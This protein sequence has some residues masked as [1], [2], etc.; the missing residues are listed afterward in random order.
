MDNREEYEARLSAAC[1]EA[2]LPEAFA[3]PEAAGKLFVVTERLVSCNRQFNL[4]AITEPEEILTKHVVDS[5]F[6][7]AA[8]GTFAPGGGKLLDV[9]AGGGFPSLPVAAALPELSVL[10]MDATAKKCRYI[11]ETAAAAGMANVAVLNARAEEAS[12][13]LGAS[14]D[15]V[16]ARAVARLNV[17][18]ELC[19][20]LCRVG[21]IFVAMKG[22]GGDE[23]AAEAARA[24]RTLG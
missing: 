18:A 2:G 14:F 8:I 16:T 7:A 1:R 5:L 21:G 6:A 4:T 15:F 13:S 20:P 9:G 17:L 24:L 23:E 11:E 19:A 10:A 12:S 22:P 3:S